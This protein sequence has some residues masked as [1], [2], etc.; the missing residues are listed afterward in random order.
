M[1]LVRNVFRLKFGKAK[2]ALALWKEGRQIAERVGSGESMRAMTDLVGPFYTLVMEE[3][4][5]SLAEME[6]E[7]QSELGA[8]EWK[9]WYQKFVP[10]VESGYR[11]VF[12][13]VE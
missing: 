8:E 13:I 7:L 1:I 12:T 10:L 4:F 5:P 9:A 6:R 2:D 3:E 11:E